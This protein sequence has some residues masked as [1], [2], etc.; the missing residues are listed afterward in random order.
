MDR[1][2]VDV[3]LTRCWASAHALGEIQERAKYRPTYGRVND[4]HEE[5]ILDKRELEEAIQML[6]GQEDYWRHVALACAAEDALEDS[7]DESH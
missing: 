5:A 2:N 3:L 4:V 6:S 1:L 7:S